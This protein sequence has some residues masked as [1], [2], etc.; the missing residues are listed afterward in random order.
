MGEAFASGLIRA[1]FVTPELITASCP[2]SQRGDKLRL[3]LGINVTTNNSEATQ[4]ADLVLLSV[5]PQALNQV[6]KSISG[7]LGPE[8]LVISI[9]AGASLESLSEK[10]GTSNIV[11]AMP[12]TPAKIGYGMTLWYPSNAVSAEFRSTAEAVFDTLGSSLLATSEEQLNMA[13]ALSGSG[14]AYAFLFMEALIDAGVHLGF[15]RYMAEQLVTQTV[16]GSVEY[17]LHQPGHMANLRDA[18]TSP[19]G[20]TAEALYQFEKAGFRSAISEAVWAAYYR[21]QELGSGEPRRK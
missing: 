10:L 9:V 4:G 17:Y 20:T 1:N 12:N 21:S 11:R 16:K 19:G 3:D 14:P 6:A 18:V 15:P 8:A 2:R 7:S 13:T 5:K